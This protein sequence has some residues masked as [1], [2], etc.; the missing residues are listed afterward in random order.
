MASDPQKSA[1][2]RT[3]PARASVLI[4]N[5][6]GRH[7]LEACLN[8]LAAQ[9]CRDFEVVLVDNGSADGSVDYLR[10]RFPWVKL[11]P[12][13]ENTGFAGGNNVALEHAAGEYLIALNNDTRVEP[14]WLEELV[15]VADENPRAGMV[16]SRICS[17]DDP[18][19]VDSLGVKVCLDG[20]SRGAHRLR[21]FSELRLERVE[22]ILLPSACAALYRR[23]MI[24]EVGFFDER[25][26]AYCEDTDLGLRGRR[27]GWEA[28]LA[29]GA[30]VY[31]KYS[32]T[33]GGFSPLKLYL[34]ERNHY[35]AAFRNFPL[36]LLFLLPF[37][38]LLRYLEQVR[39]VARGEGSG[40]EFRA[41]DSKL[42][43]VWA[44]LKGTAGGIARL[45]SLLL[46]RA[47]L[48]NGRGLS[49]RGMS[50]LL[51]QYR[52]SFKELLDVPGAGS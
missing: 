16:G 47:R 39:V 26:F 31:H 6:N 51:R 12:L 42:Q 27:A 2:A 8:S 9:T 48:E 19:L 40:G 17:Y 52:L 34:V 23:S 1:P 10:K 20:M 46:W 50:S 35:W 43:L 37:T 3:E 25:F 36:P 7:H 38:T 14:G 22:P 49:S 15:R 41:G 30:V 24:E 33:G 4:V 44:I 28:L 11:V 13:D 29:T 32:Q 5:W 18:D 45:P 21:K